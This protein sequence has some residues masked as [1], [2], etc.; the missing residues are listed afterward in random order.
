M[1]TE[2]DQLQSQ[3]DELEKRLSALNLALAAIEENQQ[4]DEE[5]EEE[6]EQPAV[7]TW[8]TIFDMS[9]NDSSINLG[10]TNGLMGN[11]TLNSFPD[12]TNFSKLR[13]WAFGASN[14]AP[15]EFD[16]SDKVNTRTHTMLFSNSAGTTIYVYGFLTKPVDNTFVISKINP[17]MRIYCQHNKATT[18]SDYSQNAL[19]F[20]RKI[21]AM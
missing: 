1:N 11:T 18:V 21:E 16:I 13:V 20:I 9:S 14:D 17:F 4:S 2:F 6:E 15:Y 19:Y 10:Y 3:V 8:T 5:E 7:P 12:L